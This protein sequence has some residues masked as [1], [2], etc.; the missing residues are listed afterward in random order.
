MLNRT[1][2]S[3]LH[4]QLEEIF[5]AKLANREWLPQQKIPSE[6]ELCEEYGVSRGTIRNVISK[7]VY[8]GLFERVPGKGT[9][10]MESKVA[11]TPSGSH[12]GVSHDLLKPED[13]ARSELVSVERV[14]V[15]KSP[16]GAAKIKKIFRCTDEEEIFVITI[17]SYLREAPLIHGLTIIPCRFCPDLE[18][19]I[20]AGIETYGYLDE[21]LEKVYHL[22]TSRVEEIL[23]SIPAGDVCAASL[24][25]RNGFPLL[26]LE[27][28]FYTEDQTPFRYSNFTFRGDRISIH[29][30]L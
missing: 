2:I 7:F 30:K 10:V 17:V 8:E 24:K 12:L 20:H 16:Y 28:T 19:R 15:G 26:L 14:P 3:P 27:D 13:G 23:E 11:F 22:K 25:V 5:R 6:N 9:F 1:S 29:I 21:F 18:A 4:E